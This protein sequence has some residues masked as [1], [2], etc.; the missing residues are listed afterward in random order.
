M[1]ELVQRTGLGKASVYRLFPTKDVLIGAYLRRLA[2]H[3]LA[4]IDADMTRHASDPREALRSIMRAVAT[5][6][7]RA[8][9]RGCPFNNAS[10]EFADPAHPARV[11]AREYRAELLQRLSTLGEQL[12]PGTGSILG[13]QLAL[14]IDGMYVN[15]AHLGAAG[16]AA[17]GTELAEAVIAAHGPS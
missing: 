11:V 15:A 2:G 8:E 14:V 9:F 17:V 4:S 5:D 6:V 16:P 3:I 1:D 10:V 13:A 12:A 7:A